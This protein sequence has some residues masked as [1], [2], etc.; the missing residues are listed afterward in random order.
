MNTSNKIRLF[1]WVA[2][3]GA[4]LLA[5]THLTI[6]ICLVVV[7]GS[8]LI[9]L[10][11]ESKP[12]Q[13][14]NEGRI[15]KKTFDT[16]QL[17]EVLNRSQGV[18]KFEQL[19]TILEVEKSDEK[20]FPKRSLDQIISCLTSFGYAVVPNY[21][22]GHRR[23]TY[24][25]VCVVYRLPVSL[26]NLKSATM[27]Q[28]EMFFKLLSIVVSGETLSSGDLEY[29]KQCIRDLGLS[30]EFHGHFYAYML[31]LS[32][33]KQPFD[34]KT[35]DD[36]MLFPTSLKQIYAKLL[37]NAV[38]VNGDIDN[39]RVEALKKVLPF[40]GFEANTV[41]SLLHQTLTDESVFAKIENSPQHIQEPHALD[42]A[43]LNEL[44]E[45]TRAAQN[46][47]SEI[48]VE[49]EDAP[50]PDLEKKESSLVGVLSKLLE[51]EVW[52]HDEIKALV[53]PDVMIGNLLEDIN[54]YSY[55][56]VDDIVVEEDGDQIYVTT[57]YKN[58][59][60]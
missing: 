49:E 30:S 14:H 48:F 17:D 1:L 26:Y 25:D 3:I 50:A 31:W 32:Q 20:T 11:N 54:D 29:I 39:K 57:E 35:K 36:L 28:K 19:L 53:G 60:I 7:I 16:L 59:L 41:H 12:K 56:K 6:A 33:K 58:Q 13:K 23:L 55:S 5:F 15:A 10:H 8:V 47:L 21:Q 34:K 38:H 52:T 43:K 46:L 22:L 4:I 40:L 37:L 2:L 9:A 27:R 24:G 51:K 18:L 42:Q 44:K 45:Q